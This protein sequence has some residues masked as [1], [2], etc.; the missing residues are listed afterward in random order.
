[1]HV[2]LHNLCEF[3]N[4]SEERVEEQHAYN[5]DFHLASQENRGESNES[6]GRKVKRNL[7]KYFDL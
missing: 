3:K 5:C 6:G 2:I 4:V 1:M 7:T